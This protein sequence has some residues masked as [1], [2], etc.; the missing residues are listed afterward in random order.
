VAPA[1]GKLSRGRGV[2]RMAVDEMLGADVETGGVFDP[3]VGA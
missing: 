2:A 3:L 1:P